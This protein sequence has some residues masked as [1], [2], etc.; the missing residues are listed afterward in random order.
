VIGIYLFINKIHSFLPILALFKHAD[1]T[2]NDGF[3]FY[4]KIHSRSP[5]FMCVCA[6]VCVRVS[7][8]K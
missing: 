2:A 7:K 6:G 8:N 3:T 1:L 4:N 5:V